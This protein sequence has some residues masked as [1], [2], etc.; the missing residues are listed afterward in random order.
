MKIDKFKTIRDFDV[1][2]NKTCCGSISDQMINS[3]HK[4]LIFGR[5]P[6]L[7]NETDFEA[8][9]L[10]ETVFSH[11]KRD[12]LVETGTYLGRGVLAGLYCEF[13]EIY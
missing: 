9:R 10:A 2:L 11:Y 8:K 3:V 6:L 7:T 1:Q 12:I 13:K 5:H 4:D